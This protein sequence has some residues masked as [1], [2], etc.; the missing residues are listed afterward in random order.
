MI[1][2]LFH[3]VRCRR[4]R[5]IIIILCFTATVTSKRCCCSNAVPTSRRNIVLYCNKVHKSHVRNVLDKLNLS[6]TR[7]YDVLD[8]S[9][10]ICIYLHSTGNITWCLFC[11]KTIKQYIYVYL[12]ILYSVKWWIIKLKWTLVENF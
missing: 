7:F 12:S 8:W 3:V 5:H 11:Y 6:Q 10:D 1:I 2:L 9:Y 4:R